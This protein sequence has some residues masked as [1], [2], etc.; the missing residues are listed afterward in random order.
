MR[1]RNKL[2][3]RDLFKDLCQEYVRK[4][5][6]L[7]MEHRATLSSARTELAAV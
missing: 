5:D 1:L 3:R 7:R 2:M 6:R 4:L